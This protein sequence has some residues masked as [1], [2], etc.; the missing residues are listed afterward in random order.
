MTLD[1]AKVENAVQVAQRWIVA[2]L[3]HHKFFSL[4]ELNKPAKRKNHA[5]SCLMTTAP[6]ASETATG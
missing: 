2:A 6:S 3:R 5:R 4:E 1:K